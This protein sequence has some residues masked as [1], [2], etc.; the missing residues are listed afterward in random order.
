VTDG[1]AGTCGAPRR[2]EDVVRLELVIRQ[3][4]VE[5]MNCNAYTA[6][7]TGSEMRVELAI[8]GGRPR[9]EVCGRTS[10]G[11]S[12]EDVAKLFDDLKAGAMAA[13][14]SLKPDFGAEGGSTE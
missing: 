12:A 1:Q 7:E 3:K 13:L 6:M 9:V 14:G 5:V 4:G 11:A 8:V 10:P 2:G